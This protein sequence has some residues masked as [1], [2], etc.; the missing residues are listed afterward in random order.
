MKKVPPYLWTIVFLPVAVI[1]LRPL[2]FRQLLSSN[3]VAHRYCYLMSP[4]LVWTNAISD[5]LIFL[6]YATLFYGLFRLAYLVRRELRSYLWVFLAFGTFILACGM[7][8][9]MEVVTVWRPMYPLSAVLKVVCVVASVPTAIAFLVY[10]R[11]MASQIQ[12][13]LL[14]MQS[15][16]KALIAS[17]RVA[18]VGRMSASISHEINNP[19]ESVMNLIYLVKTHPALPADLRPTVDLTEQEVQRVARI[20]NNTLKFYRDSEQMVTV[21]LTEVMDSIVVLQSGQLRQRRI[22]VDIDKGGIA[23]QEVRVLAHPG[24][25]RQVLI[26]L[27]ENAIAAMPQGGRLRLSLHSSAS[28]WQGRSGVVLRVA[29]TG[30]G[31]PPEVLAKVFDPFFTTKGE[32]GTGLGLWIVRQIVEK[33]GGLL[34]VKSKVGTGTVFSLWLPKEGPA[35]GTEPAWTRHECELPAELESEAAFAALFGIDAARA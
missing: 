13:Y 17:E 6:S 31:I 18:A 3:Y 33:H 11:P 20:A 25:L 23:A 8:H 32:Q 1:A 5:A 10:I 35:T 21:D 19:L 7:T 12:Q 28:A 30:T 2:W 26:N 27:V 9:F 22:Q 14:E 15:S 24:E 29:D 34:T 4:W 16:R